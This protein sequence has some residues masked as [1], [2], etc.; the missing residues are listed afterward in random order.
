M[1]I[2]TVYIYIYIYIYICVVVYIK[3]K[4]TFG[5]RAKLDTVRKVSQEYHNI[6]LK[7][8]SLIF[9]NI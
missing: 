9:I 1:Y 5:I 4:S 8:V 7:I 6:C 3:I 2:Y